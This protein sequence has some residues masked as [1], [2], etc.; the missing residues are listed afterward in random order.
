MKLS[1]LSIAIAAILNVSTLSSAY[2]LDLYVDKKTK[3]IYAEPGPGRVHM[4]S[5]VKAEEAGK[6]T[7]TPK[8]PAK[9]AQS[10]K[11]AQD[12]T[13]VTGLTPDSE[14]Q[15]AEAGEKLGYVVINC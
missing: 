13:E 4:G 5:F 10:P 9:A 2:A 15:Q 6:N 8:A 7:Q 11:D 12:K 3:Q 14:D 1:P